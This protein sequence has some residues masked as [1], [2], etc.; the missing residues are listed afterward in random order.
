MSNRPPTG[1]TVNTEVQKTP[2][3]CPQSKNLLVDSLLVAPSCKPPDE[4]LLYTK[5]T[6]GL[7]QD[8]VTQHTQKV[9][10]STQNLNPDFLTVNAVCLGCL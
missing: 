7:V 5:D 4:L 1:W 6:N 9:N 3:D 2:H 10:N 8:N